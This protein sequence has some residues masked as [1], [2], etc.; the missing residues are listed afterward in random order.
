[1]FEK[2]TPPD[3]SDVLAEIVGNRQLLE[4]ILRNSKATDDCG[5][6]L[7]W[8]SLQ[9]KTPPEDLTSEQYWFATKLAR[10][11]QQIELP[12]LDKEGNPFYYSLPGIVLERLAEVDKRAPGDLLP[13]PANGNKAVW[14]EY[15]V[16][17][18][19]DEAIY[20]SLI[21]GAN[22]T[23]A[24]ARELLKSGRRPLDLHEQMIW[25]N[26]AAVMFAQGHKENELTPDLILR[27]HRIV[28]NKTLQFPDDAG[29]LRMTN[30]IV[31]KNNRTG[32]IIH[33]PPAAESLP[34]RIQLF[35][36]FAND[37]IP[38]LSYIH[39]V[40]RAILLHYMLAYDHPFSDGNGRTARGLFY[41]SMA[42]Q[43]YWLTEYL[44]ISS[45]I[46]RP[47]EYF[48]YLRAYQHTETD[49]YDTTYF[50]LNQ[51]TV[52]L[53]A[54]DSFSEHVKYKH[55]QLM[56]ARDWLSDTYWRNKLNHRQINLI[57]DALT[58]RGG[59]YLI[60]HHKRANDIAYQTARTDL[61]KLAE[62]GLLKKIKRGKSLVF[63]SPD[64]L[65]SRLRLATSGK[66][67]N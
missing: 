5:H 41:W 26:Y 16:R 62:Y 6:Y 4:Q 59:S 64:D 49:E 35:C 55:T 9:Y 66:I 58:D 29:R 14:D 52:L 65:Y 60:N 51:L 1:M 47:S 42:R 48:E 27:L 13:L 37:K 12:F 33:V 24:V 57:L 61:L 39:P 45:I 20:S 50:I 63:E 53:K 67:L 21:E 28:T 31:I 32:E 56:E 44:S 11:T 7:H 2:I 30:D 54:Y 15:R 19:M 3:T 22:S 40:I 43:K 36:D 10:R 23:R 46:Y 38:S 34:V 25:N 17:A 8:D 18:L